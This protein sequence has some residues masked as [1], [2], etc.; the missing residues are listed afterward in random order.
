MPATMPG[1]LAPFLRLSNLVSKSAML[2]A[3]T[4]SGMDCFLQVVNPVKSTIAKIIVF[5]Q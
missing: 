3:E 4:G 1:M 5:E 2:T